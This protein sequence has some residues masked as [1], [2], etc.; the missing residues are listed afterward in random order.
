LDR[1]VLRF[2]LRPPGT[3]ALDD[4]LLLRHGCD[5]VVALGV[6]SGAQPRDAV[7]LVGGRPLR[8]VSLRLLVLQIAFRFVELRLEAPLPLELPLNPT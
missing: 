4:L 3:D 8:L 5:R 6:G 2:E 1:V 7:A